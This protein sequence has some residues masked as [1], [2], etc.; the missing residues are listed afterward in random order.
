MEFDLPF[1]AQRYIA[2]KLPYSFN[3]PQ[4]VHLDL[5]R[6]VQNNVQMVGET[7][8]LKNIAQKL[9]GV[10]ADEIGVRQI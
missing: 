3:F 10:K 7:K 6:Y 9:L 8:N 4:F 1:I 5:Y 2:N